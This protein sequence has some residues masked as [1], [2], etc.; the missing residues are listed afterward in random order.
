MDAGQ[1]RDAVPDL[2]VAV[3]RALDIIGGQ[4]DLARFQR[5]IEGPE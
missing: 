5:A 3:G 4:P 1:D 2:V